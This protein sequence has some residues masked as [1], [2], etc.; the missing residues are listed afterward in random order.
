MREKFFHVGDNVKTENVIGDMKR[1]KRILMRAFDRA[2]RG[3]VKN[4][5]FEWIFFRL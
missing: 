2:C 3:Q 5:S 1:D 4:A